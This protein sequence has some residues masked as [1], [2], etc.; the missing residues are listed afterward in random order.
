MKILL[1]SHNPI[2]DYNSMGKTMLSLFSKFQAEELMQF[3]I[4]PTIPNI[5]KCS[6]YYRVKD[7]EVLNSIFLFQKPGRR[8]S[9]NE[10]QSQNSL[11]EHV[12]DRNMYKYEAKWKTTCLICRHMIW[13]MGHWKTRALKKWVDE[14]KPDIIF[15]MPGQSAFFYDIIFYFHQKWNLP[16][17][18][19]FCDDFYQHSSLRG[20]LMCRWY[21]HLLN[22]K[23]DKLVSESRQV[24]TISD[25]MKKKYQQEFGCKT[26]TVMPGSN[27]SLS[28]KAL[29]GEKNIIGYF[30]SLE[31]GRNVSLAKIGVALDHIN[32]TLQTNYRLHIH[33]DVL[34]P[35]RLELFAGIHSICMMPFV[36]GDK[37]LPL[38]RKCCAILYTESFEMKYRNRIRY[39]LSTKIADSLASGVCLVAYAPKDIASMEYLTD[40]HCAVGI[41]EESELESVFCRLLQSTEIRKEITEQGLEIAR[42]NHDRN[43]QGLLMREIIQKNLSMKIMQINCVYQKGSTGKLV[44]ELSDRLKRDRYM[45]IICY[46]RGKRVKEYGVYKI[47]SEIFSKL[48]KLISIYTGMHYNKCLIST[49]RLL[50][51]IEK[52][53]PDIVH[54]HCINGYFVNIY[55]LVNYLK[56]NQIPTVLTLHAEF[57]YTANCPHAENCDQWID[58][59][60]DCRCGYPAADKAFLR[61]KAAFADYGKL[62]VVSVS[63]WQM[64]RAKI[65]AI[66]K[67]GKHLTI[68]NGID[69]D[70]FYYRKKN[71]IAERIRDLFQEK[72]ILYITP[73]F[74]DQNKGGQFVIR[75]AQILPKVRFLIVGYKANGTLPPN[76]TGIHYLQ[77]QNELASLYSL[78]DVTLLTSKRETYGL[79][80]AESLCCGTPVVGFLSGGPET[81]ALKQY[82]SFSTYA[83]IAVMK[84]NLEYWLDSTYDKKEISRIAINKY[85][86]QVMYEQYLQLYQKILHKS[87]G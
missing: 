25:A 22:Y 58:G 71:E 20:S 87:N 16:I 51:I 64:E 79:T 60:R 40:N 28:N 31:L 77:D 61:M 67:K 4:Y 85:N 33:S 82:S 5:Q 56:K 35:D 53:H 12:N 34:S 23:I 27:F 49:I 3:Y 26:R 1:L 57:M 78:A 70:V 80:V 74:L 52:E 41:T 59:C 43:K 7:R 2:T 63:P 47:A 68:E 54:L 73:N 44:Q 81:I 11:Y 84:E 6:S 9:N 10:I 8:I 65:S 83:D 19:Y 46:G 14:E 48:R 13:K 30:G 66:L 86:S 29:E 55:R 38:I 50:H 17:V 72:T 15:T 69:T 42:Q 62:A 45:S 39:S 75:L 21:Q 36:T 37:V 24:L 76:V 32:D 18:S